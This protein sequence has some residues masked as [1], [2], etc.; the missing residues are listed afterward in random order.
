MNKEELEKLGFKEDREECFDE[1][2]FLDCR[3]FIGI[4]I[5]LEDFSVCINDGYYNIQ[6][7]S[8]NTIEKVKQLIELLK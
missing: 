5:L 2:L 7:P 4:F 6:L 8:V 1:N 3:N